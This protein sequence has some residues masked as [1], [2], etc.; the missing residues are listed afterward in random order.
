MAV[1]VEDIAAALRRQLEEIEIK[2]EAADIGSVVEVGDGIARI[3]GLRNAVA[4]ELLEFPKEGGESI[5]GIALNLEED[6]VGAA[7]LGWVN[8]LVAAVLMPLSALAVA[9]LT[10]GAIAGEAQIIAD[11]ILS[12]SVT[13][14]PRRAWL[15]KWPSMGPTGSTS[16]TPR[17]RT[18]R[19]ASCIAGA[20][21]SK[22]GS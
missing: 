15:S 18:S 8:P 2:V 17:T 16:I 1:R 21:W 7:V 3:D 5:F 19:G 4:S 14:T 10:A 11:G 6:S 12:R 22:R 13:R 9:V 20:R